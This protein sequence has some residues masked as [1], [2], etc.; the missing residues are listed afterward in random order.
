MHHIKSSFSRHVPFCDAASVVSVDHRGGMSSLD[1]LGA[2]PGYIDALSTGLGDHY[3]IKV[4]AHALLTKLCAANAPAV[5]GAGPYTR[6]IF[7]ST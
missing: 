1:H 5:L 7:S 3:D 6:P 2:A 4:V